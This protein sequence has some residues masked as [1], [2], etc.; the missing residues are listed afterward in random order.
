[1]NERITNREAER[2]NAILEATREVSC[3]KN[4]AISLIGR[5]A[6]EAL[7]ERGVIRMERKGN[8]QH[9]KWILKL[10]DVLTVVA[11]GVDFYKKR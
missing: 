10:S 6:T 4:T 7:V 8:H 3:S 9:G 2:L 11:R 1:M 5:Q